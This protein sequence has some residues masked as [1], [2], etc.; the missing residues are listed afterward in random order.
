MLESGHRKNRV[1]T[2]RFELK[3]FG[4]HAKQP[5]D[6][7]RM[8]DL[9]GL[10]DVE[11]DPDVLRDLLQQRPLERVTVWR[12]ADFEEPLAPEWNGIREGIHALVV[13]ASNIV[14]LR[15]IALTCI[16]S[17]NFADVVP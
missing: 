3:A 7:V 4:I 6:A 2:F 13:V 10:I 17:L 9:H 15:R 11:P 12:S 8:P 16:V 14:Q 1:K 5:A